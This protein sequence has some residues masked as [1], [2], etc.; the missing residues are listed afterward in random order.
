MQGTGFYKAVINKL[1][2]RLE[3]YLDL[4]GDYVEK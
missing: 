2:P 1:V 3:K 4:G